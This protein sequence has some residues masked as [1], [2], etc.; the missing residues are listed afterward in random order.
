MHSIIYLLI[1]ITLLPSIL[2]F[3]PFER[4]HNQLQIDSEHPIT[5]FQTMNAN[6]L[7]T[8][9]SECGDY[10][11]CHNNKCK[12]DS[13]YYTQNSNNPCGYKQKKQLTA[14]LLQFF[15]GYLGAGHFYVGEIGLGVGEI[16]LCIVPA[17]FICCIFCAASGEKPCIVIFLGIVMIL[18]EIGTLAWWI[19]NTV[20]FGENKFNDSNGVPLQEW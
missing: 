8:L 9:D 7:C 16:L 20:Q 4:L 13:G 2:G 3:S 17:I 5:R 14:F 10:G 19:Y 15:I 1:F 6:T 18:A 11:R 12:C